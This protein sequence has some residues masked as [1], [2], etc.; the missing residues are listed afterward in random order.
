[1][2]LPQF[3]IAFALLGRAID[4]TEI[5]RSYGVPRG[6]VHTVGQKFYLDGKTFYFAGTNAYWISF[7]TELAD[8]EKTMDEAKAAGLRVSKWIS[9]TLIAKE[10][11][12]AQ[13]RNLWVVRTDGFNDK[14][15]TYVPDGMPKYGGDT[16]PGDIVY[17]WW[18]NGTAT[19]SKGSRFVQ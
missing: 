11:F 4:A 19:I 14:N 17:Q 16:S 8:V 1:M 6:F 13:L 7:T 2:L 15:V 9:P 3:L 5:S 18:S 10:N 12:D